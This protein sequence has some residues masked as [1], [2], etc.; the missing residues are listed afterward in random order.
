MSQTLEAPRADAAVDTGGSS[1]PGRSCPLHY[2]Y[3][4]QA[5]ATPASPGMDEL[6]TL[7]VVG[8]LYGNALALDRVCHLFEGDRGDMNQNAVDA[9]F[10]HVRE[11]S[12]PL[13]NAT[14][15]KYA[16]LMAIM[17][18]KAIDEKRAVTWDE[19]EL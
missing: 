4:P 17:G 15:G 19:V 14:Y 8:G 2:R 13:N 10:K 12:E 5:F 1:A 16:T 7:Y 9:F 6:E 3:A 18:R 11:K